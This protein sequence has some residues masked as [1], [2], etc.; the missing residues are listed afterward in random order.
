MKKY[1]HLLDVILL[2]G[3]VIL[4]AVA[5]AP[6]T[7]VMPSSLQMAV[8][9]AVIGLIAAFLTLSWREHPADERE[10]QNQATA[11]RLAYVVGSIVLI[12]SLIIQSLT[13]T[14]DPTVPLALLA[15]IATKV[16]MQ[17]HSDDL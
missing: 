11:S 5:I 7:L 16:V 4:S 13:H 1:K 12:V 10:A 6:K 2:S 17:R 9:A 14:I 3:L 15:M 8:L